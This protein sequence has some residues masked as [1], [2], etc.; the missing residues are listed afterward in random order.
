MHIV[1]VQDVQSW[2][3]QAEN[4][5]DC[6]RS[7]GNRRVDDEYLDQTL[8]LPL[9]L[10]FVIQKMAIE[11]GHTEVPADALNSISFYSLCRGLFL[12]LA[13]LSSARVAQLFGLK[14]P[15]PLDA[16]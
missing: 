8:R 4:L 3:G 2:L 14:A 12:P 5:S 7:I 11:A 6:L 10:Q 15:E 16:A 1:S 9:H 13:G